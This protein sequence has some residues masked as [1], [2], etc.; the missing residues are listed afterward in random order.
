MEKLVVVL[1]ADREQ[2]LELCAILDEWQYRATSMYSLP[3]IERYMQSS[4]CGVVIMDIDT[5]EVDDRT[6]RNLRTKNPEV[7][8]LCLS[9][10]RFHPELRESLSSHIFACI[11][12]PID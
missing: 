8:L 9:E 1:D 4:N 10:Y 11:N 5:V 7:F 6:I 12:K 2:C 3:N